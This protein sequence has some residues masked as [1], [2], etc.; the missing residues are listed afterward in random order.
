MA[1]KK[2]WDCSLDRTLELTN[3]SS[4]VA[5]SHKYTCQFNFWTSKHA[6]HFESVKLIH[7]LSSYIP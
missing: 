3:E 5:C 7:L 1:W 2:Q 6:L 4:G